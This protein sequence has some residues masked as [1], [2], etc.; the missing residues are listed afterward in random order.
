MSK[1]K[2]RKSPPKNRKISPLMIVVVLAGLLLATVGGFAIVSGSGQN[3]FAGIWHLQQAEVLPENSDDQV[4]TIDL[5]SL[6]SCTSPVQVANNTPS[7]HFESQCFY[8]NIS[9]IRRQAFKLYIFKNQDAKIRYYGS[10]L[11]RHPCRLGETPLIESDLYVMRPEANLTRKQER[12][13]GIY[14]KLKTFDSQTIMLQKGQP[15]ADYTSCDDHVD[16]IAQQYRGIGAGSPRIPDT[17]I[18]QRC[19]ALQASVDSVYTDRPIT[20]SN[21]AFADCLNLRG[22]VRQ[23]FI[24]SLVV[25]DYQMSNV[26]FGIYGWYGVEGPVVEWYRF[27]TTA[28]L[29]LVAMHE[30]LHK[31]Y[32]ED[33]SSVERIKVNQEILR[34]I[35][36]DDPAGLLPAI[37]F[38]QE[39]W[40]RL[41]P[42]KKIAL[43]P[44][45]CTDTAL[46]MMET[47]LCADDDSIYHNSEY[48]VFIDYLGQDSLNNEV[49][50]RIGRHNPSP[51]DFAKTRN[52][53][54]DLETNI[55][56]RS[57]MIDEMLVA[58]PAE[59][60]QDYTPFLLD[61]YG[62]AAFMR[63]VREVTDLEKLIK[64]LEEDEET[65][66][67]SVDLNL[68][69][70]ELLAKFNY[71]KRLA[72]IVDED[73]NLQKR[74]EE[75]FLNYYNDSYYDD[76]YDDYEYEPRGFFGISQYIAQACGEGPECEES[77]TQPTESPSEADDC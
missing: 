42:A 50:I 74:L 2:N 5:D 27:D 15:G 49:M 19:S 16:A 37:V 64:D 73:I 45:G 21:E 28:S 71:D 9:S 7:P 31:A 52:T 61:N 38:P 10:N 30:Y 22:S 14:A 68:A 70:N 17:A 62:L 33:L 24:D 54:E 67:D 32:F 13:E 18:D 11:G 1:A 63:E 35:D 12:V 48:S 56:D 4:V 69:T 25:L 51:Y 20:P 72:T 66:Y 44:Y 8:M 60:R 59:I 57:Q 23:D 29:A 58:L 26:G 55:S 3:R 46:I 53:L 41:S 75:I 65:G 6:E 39:Q 34:L 77:E 47:G 36:T 40:D 76:D 43:N